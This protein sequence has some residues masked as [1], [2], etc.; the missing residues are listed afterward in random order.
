[1]L[2]S[3]PEYS[4]FCNYNFDLTVFPLD[5]L[6]ILRRCIGPHSGVASFHVTI[7][8]FHNH[9]LCHHHIAKQLLITLW[10]VISG[11]K[12]VCA[13][14]F[15][16]TLQSTVLLFSFCIWWCCNYCAK[17]TT[18]G[19]DS[20]CFFLNKLCTTRSLW[21]NRNDVFAECGSVWWQCYWNK[22]NKP[23]FTIK[24]EGVFFPTSFYW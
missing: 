3:T 2:H 16:C 23:S 15:F 18:N 19:V 12:L 11:K 8:Y 20:A 13:P 9:F 1:M 21:D 5:E 6:S 22:T 4:L 7:I 24:E 14:V 10:A 17:L